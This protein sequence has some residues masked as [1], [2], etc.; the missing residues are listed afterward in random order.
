MA[1]IRE[2]LNQNWVGTSIGIAGTAIGIIL[3]LRFRPRPR[4]SVQP[5]SFR[6]L[7]RHSVLPPDLEFVYRGKSVPNVALSR[8]ALWNSGN[9]SISGSQI[10][11]ADQLRISLTDDSEILDAQVLT[12]TREVNQF[13]CRIRSGSNE[14]ACGFDFLDSRDGAL[15]QIIHTGSL[16][17]GILGTLRGV[18]V[19]LV[20]LGRSYQ[21][22]IEPPRKPIPVFWS[23]VISLGLSSV[24]AVV[25]LNS[26]L[27]NPM[28]TSGVVLGALLLFL[29]LFLFFAE[30]RMPPRKLTTIISYS[31]PN[32]P[33]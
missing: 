8:V 32:D 27:R 3:A 6:L 12:C 15:V 26:V 19:R 2:F 21:D 22:K 18:P 30:T 20:R 5:N 31:G 17:I 25:M 13:W 24:A 9:T 16:K 23:S 7:G 14:V 28:D 29:G 10:V 4:L 33:R 11:E 1:D